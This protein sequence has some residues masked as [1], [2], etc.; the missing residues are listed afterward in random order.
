MLVFMFEN[1]SVLCCFWVIPSP[2]RRVSCMQRYSACEVP[3]G[4][5]QCGSCGCVA[6]KAL[7]LREVSQPPPNAPEAPRAFGVC[8]DISPML[9]PCSSMCSPMLYPFS[10]IFSY[11][12][13]S[14]I[15]RIFVKTLCKSECGPK[16]MYTQCDMPA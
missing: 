8:L 4:R 10:S 13:T 9:H 11:Y 16:G 14:H 15:P 2:E 7:I 6:C 3:S 1:V 5:P 12:F